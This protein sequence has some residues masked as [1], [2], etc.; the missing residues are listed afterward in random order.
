MVRSRSVLIGSKSHD[1]SLCA[2]CNCEA[3]AVV[4]RCFF[5]PSLICGAEAENGRKVDGHVYS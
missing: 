5:T 4:S 3:A 2:V 1:G